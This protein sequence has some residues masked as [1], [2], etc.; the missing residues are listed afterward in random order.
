[1]NEPSC[2]FGRLGI[3]AMPIFSYT[4]ISTVDKSP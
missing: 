3:L 2:R 4:R 1:L